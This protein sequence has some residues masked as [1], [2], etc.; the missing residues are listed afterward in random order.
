MANK[1]KIMAAFLALKQEDSRYELKKISGGY[2]VYLS[3]ARRDATGK[4]RKTSIYKGKILPNGF[5]IKV[6][7]KRE[8]P[9][10]APEAQEGAEAPAAAGGAEALQN[11]DVRIRQNSLKYEEKLLTA[12]SMNGRISL[13]V[14]SKM[15]GLSVTATDWQVKSLEK[16]YGI[17]YLP[18]IDVTKFGYMQFFLAVKFLDKSPPAEVLKELLQKEPRIQMAMMLKGDFDLLI[19]VVAKSVEELND[20]IIISISKVIGDYNCTWTTIPFYETCGFIPLREEFIDFLKKGLLSRE[21][22]V[23]KELNRDGKSE[24]REI[25]RKYGTDRGRSS[26]SYYKLREEGKIRRITISMQKLSFRYTGIIMNTITNRHKFEKNR[27]KFLYSIIEKSESQIN[28]YL[29]VCDTVNPYG[30]MFFLPVFGNSDLDNALEK[31]SEL[32]LGIKFA[33]LIVTSVLFGNFCYR[34]FDNA[35]SVPQRI[36]ENNYNL[37]KAQRINYEES[38]KKKVHTAKLD[39]RGARIVENTD[40]PRLEEP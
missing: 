33:T 19:Y 25:D 27:S 31:L 13:P 15:L 30:I 3:S 28:K 38:G 36:L 17:K 29:F 1:E 6:R 11:E 2:Y 10:A 24:F 37:E 34:R 32:E 21:Y 35:Y 26:Y 23:L 39:I 8:H 20:E 5:F 40:E 12:L 4:L 18:E 22:A 14:L 7:H 9:K 16:R